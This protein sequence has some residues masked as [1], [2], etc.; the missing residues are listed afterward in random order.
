MTWSDAFLEQ[1]DKSTRAPIYVVESLPSSASPS[2]GVGRSW[3]ACTHAGYGHEPDL[4]RAPLLGRTRG[5]RVMAGPAQESAAD[6]ATLAALAARGAFI[7]VIDSVYPWADFRLA[8]ARVES[9]RKVG[10]VVLR[11][12][13]PTTAPPSPPLA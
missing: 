7:P 5:L 13:G 1:C 11:V 12:A 9:R 2:W 3:S 6:V 10:T 8:H 4:L